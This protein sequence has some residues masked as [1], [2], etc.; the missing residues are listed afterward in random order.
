MAVQR[1]FS[2][3]KPDATRR[4]LTGAVET[5]RR[6]ARETE[7][8]VRKLP[9][10]DRPPLVARSRHEL[11]PALAHGAWVMAQDV[12]AELVAVWTQSGGTA[13]HLSR[14]GFRVPIMAFSTDERAVRR[15]NLLYGVFPVLRKEFPKHRFD[16][17]TIVEKIVLDEGWAEP[18][19]RMVLLAGIPFD[20]PGGANTAALRIV[21]DI[22]AAGLAADG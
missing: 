12:A 13:R 2:I 11:V 8:A 20:Q 9:A 17:A 16:F 18:G 7:N 10:V 4:N 19:D 3:I 1:T 15:M 5:M 14:N 21:G 22:T 6:V